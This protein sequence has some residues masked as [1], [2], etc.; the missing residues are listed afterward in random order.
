M[1]VDGGDV[2]VISCK[3]YSG[4]ERKGKSRSLSPAAVQVVA[5]GH[6]VEWTLI[7][8]MT[9]AYFS[10]GFKIEQL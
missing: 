1:A 5:S 9:V 10:H 6:T 8:F 7:E 3:M 4:H 2:M